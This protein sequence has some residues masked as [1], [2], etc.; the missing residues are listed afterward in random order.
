MILMGPFQL[1]MSYGSMTGLCQQHK[2][3][4]GIKTGADNKRKEEAGRA[5]VICA[6]FGSSALG[7]W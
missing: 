3:R 2:E 7:C 4:V 1:R 6:W 5:G